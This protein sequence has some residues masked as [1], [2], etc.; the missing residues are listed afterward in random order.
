MKKGKNQQREEESAC[1]QKQTN[2]VDIILEAKDI[3]ENFC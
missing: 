2:L 3:R 1:I